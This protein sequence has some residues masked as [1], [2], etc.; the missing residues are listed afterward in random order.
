MTV[1]VTDVD[2]RPLADAV[3]RVAQR[4]HA[5]M[6]GNIGFDLIP[7]AN[8]EAEFQRN[9]FGGARRNLE[10]L[11]ELYIELF[12]T[13]TLPF[14]WRDFE[15]ERAAPTRPGCSR[16]PAG[17]PTRRRRQGTSTRLAHAGTT[18]AAATAGRR[19]ARRHPGTDHSRSDRIRRRDRH[20]GPDQRSRHHARLRGRRERDHPAG[21]ARGTRRHGPPGVRHRPP[22]RTRRRHW[23]STTSTCHPSTST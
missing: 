2:G 22:R 20:L 6:F 18:V 12:N 8:G 11:G 4:R 10:R 17:S 7:L 16:P 23:C 19:G 5:F 13:A 9:V 14:Y 15:P 1:T 21:A 3:V